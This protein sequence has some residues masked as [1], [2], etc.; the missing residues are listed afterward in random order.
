[1][2]NPDAYKNDL[3]MAVGRQSRPKRLII[4]LELQEH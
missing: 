1:M 4:A 2:T 3:Y